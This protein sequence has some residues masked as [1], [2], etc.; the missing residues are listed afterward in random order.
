MSITA[1]TPRSD[2]V[3]VAYDGDPAAAVGDDHEPGLDQRSTAGASRISSGSGE[4]TTRRQPFSP[5]SSHISPCSTSIRAS[6]AGRNR[7]IGLVGLVKPGSFGSTSV[8]V[9]IVA[10]RFSSATGRQRG[11]ERVHQDEA[12][13][14]LG[15]GAAPV[16]RHRRYDGRGELVLDQ[17]VADLRPVAVGDHDLDVVLDELGHRGHRHLGRRDLVLR[18]GPAVGARHGVA[19]Q[20]QHH[21]HSQ[22]VVLARPKTPEPASPAP[23]EPQDPGA[24]AARQ[25]MDAAAVA[26]LQLLAV[27]VAA[28]DGVPLDVGRHP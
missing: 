12:E 21:S 17:E 5:R 22:T 28:V 7:P 27:L 20:R 3:V 24:E 23:T 25:R 6:S 8:R 1:S 19:A 11:V 14:R 13:R 2:A 10:L 18:S 15:L 26:E 4:A 16:Q 9:T